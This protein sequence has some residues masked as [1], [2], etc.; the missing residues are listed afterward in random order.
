MDV[1]VAGGRSLVLDL[2][3]TVLR[4][5]GLD[6]TRTAPT[7]T[8]LTVAVQDHRPSLC[9]IEH[10]EDGGR[11]CPTDLIAA[12]A[13]RTPVLLLSVVAEDGAVRAAQ[14]AGA[15]GY[16]HTSAGKEALLAALDDVRAGRP[17]VR[18]PA[19][20]GLPRAEQAPRRLMSALTRRERE[21]LALLVEGTG[22]PDMA[23]ELA[24]S[25]VTV[26]SHVQSILHKLGAHSR[27]EA[28]S[29]A[30]RHGLLDDGG[31]RRVV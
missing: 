22:T 14:A 10:H 11:P 18:L 1:V 27:L 28:A 5:R 17:A 4:D 19:R 6:V 21:C 12:V 15:L 26:R 13:F 25:E 29:L 7:A 20:T 24:I 30:V 3:E 9:I 8:A 16:V 31:V 2:L 23:R